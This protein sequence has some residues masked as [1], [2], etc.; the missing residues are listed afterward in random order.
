MFVLGVV[1]RLVAQIVLGAYAT[2]DTWEYEEIADNLIAGH[3]YTYAVGPTVYV[4]AVS[5]PLYVLLTAA[6]YLVTQHSHAAMLA[7]QCLFGGA[8]AALAAW[9]AARASRTNAGWIAGIVVSL[10]PALLVY[11]AELH[12]LSLD[13][14]GFT[15]AV[16]ACVAMPNRPK[17]RR[18][19]L[20]GLLLGLVALTRSTVLSLVPIVLLWANRFKGL[21]LQSWAACTLVVVALGVYSPWPIRNSLM[22]GQFVP[23]SSESTEWLWRGTNAAAT[24]ASLTPDGRTMLASAAPEF[25]ERIAAAAESERITIYRD[26]AAAYIA[27]HPVDAVRLYVVKLGAF[28]WQ[29]QSTGLTYPPVWTTLYEVWYTAIL[30]FAAFGLWTSRRDPLALPVLVLIVS[31]VVLIGLT[32]AVFYVEGRH[33]LA[34]EPLIV[35]VASIGI[36]RLS[37]SAYIRRRQARWMYQ[38]TNT[39]T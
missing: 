26:A 22:L 12:P 21:R 17:V 27:Q 25:Q 32:Q 3:G 20:I 33:R 11:S 24:G 18:A 7:L 15:A 23:G 4:A 34:I 37:T 9:L 5:S 36:W 6:V 16:C 30:V 19:A 28:I 1:A 8:T 29:S 35:V 39:T 13:A 2:P 38:A 14:L 31:W 10:E